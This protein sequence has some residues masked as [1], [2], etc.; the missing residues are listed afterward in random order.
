MLLRI[1][2]AET[3]TGVDQPGRM[4]E[5]GVRA[6]TE[7]A[8]KLHPLPLLQR[9]KA[10]HHVPDK[11]GTSG[12]TT[13]SKNTRDGERGGTEQNTTGPGGRVG[14][15][16]RSETDIDEGN[17][18]RPLNSRDEKR[19]KTCTSQVA[20]ALLAATMVAA[21][22]RMEVWIDATEQNPPGEQWNEAKPGTKYT[23]R[24]SQVLAKGLVFS[25]PPQTEALDS[26]GL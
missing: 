15:R 19:P 17:D 20:T 13:R 21:A 26:S 4:V 23:P 14:R 18:R 5:A 11:T 12:P 8:A 16:R 22:A 24:T 3:D 2:V 25:A 1:P 9:D 6:P 10:S 7:V